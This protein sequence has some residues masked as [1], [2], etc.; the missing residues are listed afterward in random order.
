MLHCTQV[1]T[2][3][4]NWSTRKPSVDADLQNQPPSKGP[5]SKLSSKSHFTCFLPLSGVAQPSIDLDNDDYAFEFQK[6][7]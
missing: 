1:N 7:E 6:N 5:G 4:P 3:P 2:P